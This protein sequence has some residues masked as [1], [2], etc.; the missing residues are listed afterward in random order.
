M[1]SYRVIIS[2]DKDDN[3]CPEDNSIGKIL[4]TRDPNSVSA[5]EVYSKKNY[6]DNN[7]ANAKQ[8][9]MINTNPVRLMHEAA[10]KFG[11]SVLIAELE[12]IRYVK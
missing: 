9:S 3:V 2:D 11:F 1:F 5:F 10:K 6:S 8:K 4:G 7:K 12:K